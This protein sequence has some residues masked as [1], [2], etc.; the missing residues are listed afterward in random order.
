LDPL[1]F[2]TAYTLSTSVGIRPFLTLA[3]ASLAM[4]LGYLH[5]AHEFAFL[6]SDG[7]TVLLASFAML[8]FVAE[9][10]PAVDHLLHVIHIA[11]KP[12]AAAILVGSAAPDVVQ[13]DGSAYTYALMGAAALNA[14]GV[15]VGVA[16]LRGASTATTAGLANPF[17]SLI[18]DAA[19]VV[20]TALAL[21]APLAGAA[22]AF[23][24]TLLLIFAAR[25]IIRHV[26]PRATPAQLA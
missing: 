13:G 23:V 17:I 4:H 5:P 16:T 19:T 21:L 6:G 7:A 10:V 20:T 22:L 8:E 3:L 2:A 14:L 11:A 26:R 24:V 12:L 9:K 25:A 1:L 15:H 18:E